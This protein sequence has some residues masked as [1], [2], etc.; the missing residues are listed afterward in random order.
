MSHPIILSALWSILLLISVIS[1]PRLISH[2]RLHKFRYAWVV[3]LCVAA[4]SRLVPNA[5]LQTG[6]GY[7]IESYQI[8]ADT[9]LNRQDVYSNPNAGSRHPYLPL[10]MYWLALSRWVA[11]R[12]SL[13]F[14]SVVR[15]API[16]AD[17]LIADILYFMLIKRAPSV[18]F[19]WWDAVCTESN[20]R[21]C[22]GLPR[23]V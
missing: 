4:I 10:Q 11:E 12:F 19:F 8:V 2:F 3:I 22:L 14:V 13:P 5:I 20:S 6:A 21:I 17:I 18:V 15:I 16:L 23:S 7:N 1:L 9:V